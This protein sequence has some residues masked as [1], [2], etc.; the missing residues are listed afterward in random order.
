LWGTVRDALFRLL[1]PQISFQND[2]TQFDSLNYK[3]YAIKIN[4]HYLSN[5][6]NKVDT[7]LQSISQ[8]KVRA[9]GFIEPSTME[10]MQ[11]TPRYGLNQ[12]SKR[13]ARSGE[14]E[15][16]T[17]GGCGICSTIVSKT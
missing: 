3:N 2:K 16:P 6:E 14:L 13:R 4:L 10:N 11:I 8:L 12:E 1:V 9:P 15:S 7:N 17:L 5:L